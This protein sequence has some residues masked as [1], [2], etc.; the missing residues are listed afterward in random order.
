MGVDHLFEV[1]HATVTD[2]D[3]VSVKDLME[4]MLLSEFRVK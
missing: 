3:F 1:W 2:L 4:H